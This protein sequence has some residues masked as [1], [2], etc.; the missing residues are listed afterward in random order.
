MKEISPEDMVVVYDLK[1][2]FKRFFFSPEWLGKTDRSFDNDSLNN[3]MI[4]L[5]SALYDIGQVRIE[6]IL[7]ITV[8]STIWKTEPT[9]ISS[10]ITEF[11]IKKLKQI[12]EFLVRLFMKDDAEDSKKLKE[13][14]LY[15]PNYYLEKK[16]RMFVDDVLNSFAIR[17][18]NAIERLLF[19]PYEG[20]TY[21]IVG[22]RYYSIKSEYTVTI[23]ETK[24]DN[25]TRET[26]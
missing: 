24:L 26:V 19:K 8:T 20:A 5:L 13:F 12:E 25:I 10:V 3:F 11:D 16:Y 9:K 22:S 23:T 6:G 21:I 17:L 15:F 1:D 4:K 2:F 7:E 18:Y 14:L